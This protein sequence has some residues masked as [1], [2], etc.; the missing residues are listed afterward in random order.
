MK[1][2]KRII[3]KEVGAYGG[4][5]GYSRLLCY[6]R[7]EDKSGLRLSIES[8]FGTMEQRFLN[9]Q[10]YEQ[11]LREP[12]VFDITDS[13]LSEYVLSGN[14]DGN[15]KKAIQ[16]CDFKVQTIDVVRQITV[17]DDCD[18][19]RTVDSKL[20]YSSPESNEKQD[21]IYPYIQESFFKR[22]DE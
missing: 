7:V 16:S 11:A 1:N 21:D 10:E 20:F 12:D 8:T 4:L 15:L 17:I 22:Y 18:E 5:D 19:T 3:K 2:H 6:K 9:E 13:E 14:C